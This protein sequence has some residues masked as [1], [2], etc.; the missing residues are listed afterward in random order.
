MVLPRE[1]GFR[2]LSRTVRR[3][4]ALLA[5]AVAAA[6]LA[7][8]GLVASWSVKSPAQLAS[9]LSPPPPRVL[10]AEV[11]SMPLAQTVAVRAIVEAPATFKVRSLTA[12]SSGRRV[13]TGRPLSKGAGVESGQVVLEI[14]G[15]P[16]FAMTGEVPAYRDLGRGIEGQDVRQLQKALA[17][18]GDLSSDLVT[19]VFD[20]RTQ[21]A[22]AR[23]YARAGYTTSGS[24]NA[25][26]VPLSELSFVPI[27]P[28]TIASVPA[29]SGAPLETDTDPL[30]E[31]NTGALM[32]QA[33][34]PSGEQG[35][36]KAGQRVLITDDIAGRQMD[37]VVK[38]V[39]AFTSGAG[40]NARPD[41]GGTTGAQGNLGGGGTGAG[42]NPGQGTGARTGYPVLVAP[43]KPL[44]LSW[45]GLSVRAQ[46]VGAA[47]DGPVLTVPSSAVVSE[48][49]GD[50]SVVVLAGDGT[51]TTVKVRTGM[52]SE[53][54]V[55][56]TPHEGGT[57]HAGDRV[58]TG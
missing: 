2:S 12:G 44:D 18:T 54:L 6:V 51:R 34:V 23:L 39:G 56:V 16:L 33:M 9:E 29:A 45:L 55:E 21:N 50:T 27:L 28:A 37:G 20:W 8:G 53:G 49:S 7:V 48:A 41:Q 22:V 13:V 47:T 31:L 10:T 30:I 11:R 14:S 43:E 40:Q 19:G 57:L 25:T 32:V 1:E 4:R 24:G 46:I 35:G 52:I 58:V 36:I 15:R 17:A 5:V 3:Q 26:I 38:E 42:L